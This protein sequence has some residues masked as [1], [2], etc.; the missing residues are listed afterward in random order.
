MAALMIDYDLNQP[1]Q[2]Y[3]A[4]HEAIMKLSGYWHLLQST[5]V[6]QAD[7]TPVQVRDYLLSFVDAS[8][9][10]FVVDVS[11]SSAVWVGLGE[12]GDVWLQT[13]LR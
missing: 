5:W 4:L 2:D 1:G 9:K 12:Q 6:V 10:L 8:S 7:L 11:H 3:A 13:V